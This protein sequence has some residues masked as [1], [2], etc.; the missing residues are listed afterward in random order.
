MEKEEKKSLFSLFADSHIKILLVY[1]NRFFRK[2][3]SLLSLI[4][5][6]K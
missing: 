3:T 2:A 6:T 1:K 4:L 5:L